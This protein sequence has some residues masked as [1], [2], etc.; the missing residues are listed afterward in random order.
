MV[1]FLVPNRR[2]LT[3]QRRASSRRDRDRWIGSRQRAG[4]VEITEDRRTALSEGG[5][6]RTGLTKGSVTR[7]EAGR[8]LRPIAVVR[9]GTVG[10]GGENRSEVLGSGQ[11]RLQATRRQRSAYQN[12]RGAQGL[13]PFCLRRFEASMQARSAA[14]NQAAWNR[15]RCAPNTSSRVRKRGEC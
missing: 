15:F 3:P 10:P 6:G 13:G 7:R 4:G 8:E 14:G 9:K 5:T 1:S 11:E 2:G 12:R